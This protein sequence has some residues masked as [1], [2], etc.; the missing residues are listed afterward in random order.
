MGTCMLAK[1][2]KLKEPPQIVQFNTIEN[3]YVGDMEDRISNYEVSS[4]NCGY[5]RKIGFNSGYN[6]RIEKE[7]EMNDAI[8]D[9]ATIIACY[10]QMINR[11]NNKSNK[12]I[13]HSLSLL[14]IEEE[15]DSIE[16]ERIK[17]MISIR[18]VANTP[19]SML[20]PTV[21]SPKMSP[22]AAPSRMQTLRHEP[23]PKISKKHLQNIENDDYGDGEEEIPVRRLP[24]RIIR[25][26][27]KKKSKSPA[28]YN[29]PELEH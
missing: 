25:R 28:K 20:S 18:T 19:A 21:M 29:Q 15:L 14:D 4:F 7:I 13:K 6:K 27:K 10:S 3:E 8:S 11:T 12:S 5:N 22:R 9:G 23:T 26:K 1:K 24:K 17:K 2:Q 16:N